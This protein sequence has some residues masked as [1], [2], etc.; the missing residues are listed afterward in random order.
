MCVSFRALGPASCFA[1]LQCETLTVL[2]MFSFEDSG[3]SGSFSWAMPYAHPGHTKLLGR[4][5]V[6]HA[7]LLASDAILSHCPGD[8]LL[9]SS[10]IEIQSLLKLP[11]YKSKVFLICQNIATVMKK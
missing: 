9:G 10:L 2:F 1:Q 3:M 6:C 8:Y 7:S 5:D 11:F 4:G